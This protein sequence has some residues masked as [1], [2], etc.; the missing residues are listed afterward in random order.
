MGHH[1][2]RQTGCTPAIIGITLFA[3]M[4]MVF[5]LI[6]G[7]AATVLFFR[8]RT[9]EQ[10]VWAERERAATE[11]TRARL[12][13]EDA[14]LRAKTDFEKAVT[15]GSDS[16]A[17]EGNEVTIEIDEDG[18]LAV[19]GKPAALADLRTTLLKVSER[20]GEGASVAIKVDDR[21][22]F[23]HVARVIAICEEA[24]IEDVRIRSAEIPGNAADEPD[25]P[26]Q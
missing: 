13:A 19:N 9:T 8:M 11:A 3:G 25:S 16:Q 7:G 14:E 2:D 6:A 10:L 21:C 5:L 20:A 23:R 24:G 4:L 1:T 12:L 18:N 17:V 15:G 22:V 26:A